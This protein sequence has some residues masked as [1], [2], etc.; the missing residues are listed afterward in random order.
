MKRLLTPVAALLLVL[1]L[2][3]TSGCSKTAFAGKIECAD[4]SASGE[5]AAC[6]GGD[7]WRCD[8][9]G[10]VLCSDCWGTGICNSC[11]GTCA[12]DRGLE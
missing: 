7:C 1:T 9:T 8:G 12:L 6:D 5:C 4:C 10:E 2:L 3:L 11:I